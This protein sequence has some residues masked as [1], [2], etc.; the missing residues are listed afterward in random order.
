MAACVEELGLLV[1]IAAP[2]SHVAEMIV[3]ENV[4]KRCHQN[5]PGDFQ[6]TVQSA[7]HLLVG[8]QVVTVAFWG[9]FVLDH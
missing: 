3:T 8:F 9:I 1:D 7:L 5:K 4:C 2:N 6:T